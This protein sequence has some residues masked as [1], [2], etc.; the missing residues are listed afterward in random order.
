MDVFQQRW[1]TR[2]PGNATC[3][4]TDPC[5]WAQ[6]LAAF[7]NIAIRPAADYGELLFK[8]GSG[9]SGGFEGSV[10]DFTI[11]VT[12]TVTTYDFEP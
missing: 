5:T 12:S 4:I 10:D 3:P 1:F 8:A 6:V 9:W 11:G 2:A 7:P